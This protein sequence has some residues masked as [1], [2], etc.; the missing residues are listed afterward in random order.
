M[1]DWRRTRLMRLFLS[2]QQIL[3]DYF[4]GKEPNKGEPV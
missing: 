4:D 2:V 3:K 1:L